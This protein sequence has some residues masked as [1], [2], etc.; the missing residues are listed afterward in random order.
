MQF[1][2]PQASLARSQLL[3]VSFEPSKSRESCIVDLTAHQM[4][5]TCVRAQG[6]E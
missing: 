4:D 5:L 6:S 2:T 1:S 3:V